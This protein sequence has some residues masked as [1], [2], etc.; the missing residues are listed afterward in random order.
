MTDNALH[1]RLQ[2]QD[3]M[4]NYAAA[5]DE[6]DRARYKACFTDDVEVVGFGTGTYRGCDDWVAYVWDALKKYSV[7]QH[8]LGPVLAEVDGDTALTRTDVQAVHFPV[9]GGARFILWATYETRMRREADSWK[10]CRHEL[11]VRGTG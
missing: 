3:L 2:L 8:M 6:R 9:E 10:I 1:D 7:T 4:L 5:V 11:I